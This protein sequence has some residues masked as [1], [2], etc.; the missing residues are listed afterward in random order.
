MHGVTMKLK[1][2]LDEVGYLD[3]KSRIYRVTGRIH[4]PSPPLHPT[5]TAIIKPLPLAFKT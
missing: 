4:T 5:V 3:H 1:K 2:N